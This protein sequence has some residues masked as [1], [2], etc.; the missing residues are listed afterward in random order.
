[1]LSMITQTWHNICIK[2]T[3]FER[4][5][6]LFTSLQLSIQVML[7]WTKQYLLVIYMVVSNRR[8]SHRKVVKNWIEWHCMHSESSWNGIYSSYVR[9]SCVLHM[10]SLYLNTFYFLSFMKIRSI[11]MPIAHYASHF[12]ISFNNPNLNPTLNPSLDRSQKLGVINPDVVCLFHFQN[13]IKR[14]SIF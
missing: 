2:L 3:G 1:M 8:S 12:E 6:Q 13:C 11:A 10:I 7:I 14:L 5:S 9:E 4:Q